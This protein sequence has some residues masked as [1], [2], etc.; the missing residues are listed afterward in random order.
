LEV[1]E[2]KGPDVVFGMKG[3]VSKENKSSDLSAGCGHPADQEHLEADWLM[4][5]SNPK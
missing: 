2:R 4:R 5:M 3:Y 1:R